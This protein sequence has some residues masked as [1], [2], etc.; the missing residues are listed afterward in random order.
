MSSLAGAIFLDKDG[1]LL[2]DEPYNVDPQRMKLARGA[3]A[4]LRRLGS[5]DMP[6]VVVSNQ[7]GVALGRFEAHALDAVQHELCRLFAVNGAQLSGFYFCPHAP[8]DDADIACAC[9]KPRPGLLYQAAAALRID[10]WKSWVLGDILDDIEAGSR[11]GCRTILIDCGNE[12]QWRRRES[13]RWLRRADF[14]VMDFD[15][16]AVLVTDAELGATRSSSRY[17]EYRI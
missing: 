17:P 11:A 15:E 14:T 13:T 12:T 6:L 9:R 3:E 4:G 2:V 5:L 16:A 8:G 10:L 1:T 7:P